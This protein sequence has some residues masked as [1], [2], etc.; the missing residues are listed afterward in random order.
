ML[1]A[2]AMATAADARP[3]FAGAF[4]LSGTP[5][6]IARGPDGN[7]W[8]TLSDS[9]DNN[10]LARV[11]PN[12]EVTE[13]AP[14]AVVNPVGI[15]SGPDGN[16]WLTRNGGVIRV[17]PADPDLAQ[18]FAIG[19]IT[20]P[21]AIR[22]GPG[23]MLWTASADQLVSIPPAN[24]AAGFEATTINGMAA[25]GIAASGGRL[26]IADFGG[27]RIVSTT[28]GGN[29]SFFDV[30]GGPQEVAGG[31][32][33]QVAYSNPISDPQTVGRIRQGGTARRTRVPQT[34][35][36][37]IAFAPD[38]HWWIAEFAKHALGLLSAGG[39]VEQFE[40]LPDNSGPRYLTVGSNGTIWVSLETAQ[41]VAK[42]KGVAPQTKITRRP[43]SPVE[44]GRGK[45]RV[46]FRFRSSA[47]ASSFKCALKRGGRGANFRRCSS[48][49]DY[50]VG[51]GRYTFLVRA[52]SMGVTDPSPA[53]DR[54]EVI[55]G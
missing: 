29:P 16:L 38:G 45:A 4:D 11:R 7:I 13:F 5:G 21:Q 48:P 37:G 47:R 44:A 42:I 25:R 1:I 50:R 6:H 41:K 39:R 52:K 22:S 10:T 27:Q 17:P 18:D 14:A 43:D 20:Q 2:L 36:F 46:K 23:G 34:D 53:K 30:G 33:K 28:P 35:P 12:G 40:G 54:F 15:T 8:L 9:G 32:S 24:P 55:R 31:P 3:R 19:A 51:P 26:W 49:K